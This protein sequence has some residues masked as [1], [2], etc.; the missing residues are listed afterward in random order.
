MKLSAVAQRGSKKDFVD[1]YAILLEHRPLPDLLELYQKKYHLSDIS[2]LLIGL[3][4]F[5]DAEEEPMPVMLW[6]VKWDE[7]KESIRK[8]LREMTRNL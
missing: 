6:R 1:V 3:A 2:H 4:Y 5:D 7:V 8:S